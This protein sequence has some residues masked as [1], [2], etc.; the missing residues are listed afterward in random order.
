MVGVGVATFFA[1][2]AVAFDSYA[3]GAASKITEDAIVINQFGWLWRR[4]RR[5]RARW[6]GSYCRR[7]IRLAG[8]QPVLPGPWHLPGGAASGGAVTLRGPLP[9]HCAARPAERTMKRLL[10]GIVLL[11][12]GAPATSTTRTGRWGAPEDCDDAD[13]AVY[14]DAYEVCDGIDNDRNG[15]V[16]ETDV[17]GDGAP[18]CSTD[19]DVADCDDSD[20][21][22]FPGAPEL[23]DLADN[24]C[25]DIVD[26][27]FDRDLDGFATRFGDCDDTDSTVFPD[28]EEE[29]DN[30]DD[31][32]DGEIDEGFDGDGDGFSVCA[33]PQPDCDDDREDIYPGAPEVCDGP[34]FDCNGVPGNVDGDGDGFPACTGDC[35]DEEEAGLGA[36]ELCNFVDDDWTSSSTRIWMSIWTAG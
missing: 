34:D 32:C 9:D 20:P 12:G 19:L 33:E 25:N 31:D 35:D 13:A 4:G 3:R 26:D 7:S 16:D 2:V 29:C 22:T 27:P 8:L 14:P 18:A 28:A 17:D 23:C 21:R 10:L 24:D 1:G 5:S 6:N 36:V 30:V 15:E 11:L